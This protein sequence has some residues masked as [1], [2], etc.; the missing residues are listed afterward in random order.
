MTAHACI[1]VDPG[2]STGM[3]VV[4]LEDH[5]AT[6]VGVEEVF[7]VRDAWWL[8]AYAGTNRL[9]RE[10][11][12]TCGWGAPAFVEAIPATFREGSIEGVT[13]GHK[14]WS[15]LGE[16]RGLAVG[17]LK[18]ASVDVLD[19]DQPKWVEVIGLF[20]QPIAAGKNGNDA[21][22][23]IREASSL[24]AGAR[25]FFARRTPVAPGTAKSD[26]TAEQGRSVDI[27]ESML[28]SLAGCLLLRE[29]GVRVPKSA[30]R[31]ETRRR[32]SGGRRRTRTRAGWGL[33]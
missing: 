1:G 19:I 16:W 6:L 11:V 23:R 30:L 32:S 22:L 27:A 20:L 3:S 24:I 28:I 2:G 8:R 18:S 15:G 33:R 29:H 5:R 7:G 4:S 9:Q 14:T 12:T 25:E 31:G 10:V 21:G 17:A 26:L 13:R